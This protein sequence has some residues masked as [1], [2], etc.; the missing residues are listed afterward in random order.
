VKQLLV[1]FPTN[2]QLARSVGSHEFNETIFQTQV[3]DGKTYFTVPKNV[4][5]FSANLLVVSIIRIAAKY[6]WIP[7]LSEREL[8][9]GVLMTNHGALFAGFVAQSLRS[10]TGR[11]NDSPSQYGKGVKAFQTYSVGRR[12]NNPAHLRT[13][14]LDKITRTLSEMKGFTKEHWG[15]RGTIIALFKGLEPNQ[16]SDISTYLL[17]A[18]E[19]KKLVKTK[20]RYRNGGLLRPEEISY[21]D[22]RYSQQSALLSAF[23]ASF[24]TPSVTLAMHFKETYAPI[25]TAVE[26]IDNECSLFMTQR[27]RIAFPTSKR[28]ADIAFSKLSLGEK[29]ANLDETKL[30]AFYPESLP[31]IS[32]VPQSADL[33]PEEFIA[34]AYPGSSNDQLAMEVIRSWHANLTSD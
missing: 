29:L 26:R 10:E 6:G 2:E 5:S 11:L 32:K 33:P 14:G 1:S 16:V 31:G 17:P 12:L 23:V 13:G 28:K 15:L 24:D 22:S 30:I 25:K 27:S 9:L 20:L 21:L 4:Q 18:G 34:A 3:R 19:L 7:Q 8:P